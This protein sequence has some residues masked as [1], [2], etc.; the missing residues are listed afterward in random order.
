M[1]DA[2]FA[3]LKAVH[4]LPLA[5]AGEITL[6]EGLS[7]RSVYRI[8]GQ[9]TEE[10]L[11]A[12]VPR[13]TPTLPQSDRYF[14]TSDGIG[15]LARTMGVT[16]GEVIRMY[17]VSAEWLEKLSGR[18]DT[19]AAVYRAAATSAMSVG[20]DSPVG[21]TF[22]RTGPLD[23]VIT[24]PDGCS[25]GVMRQGHIA[26]RRTINWKVGAIRRWK[27]DRGPRTVLCLVQTVVD[28]NRNW[29]QA[30]KG[31]GRPEVYAYLETEALL[32][33]DDVR[34]RPNVPKDVSDPFMST[35]NYVWARARRAR[36]IPSVDTVWRARA[37]L[38][39]AT[40]IVY[41]TLGME[42]NRSEIQ[43][44]NFI[45]QW[46]GISLEELTN[47]LGVTRQRVQE[48]LEALVIEWGLVHD[49]GSEGIHRYAPTYDGIRYWTAGERSDPGYAFRK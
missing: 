30:N 36:Q 6:I 22:H 21:V 29:R 8:L 2:L 17:P 5:D 45:A 25:I 24:M 32:N 7:E 1:N 26:P 44:F 16:R 3:T 40:E 28:A 10:G 46:S 31:Q 43:A 20:D 11:I 38:P 48:L 35:L 37:T 39:K 34:E 12:S 42:L 9:L 49:V 27:T 4:R 18:V 15:K 41:E 33:G 13:G 19:V 14:P 23:A 47:Y